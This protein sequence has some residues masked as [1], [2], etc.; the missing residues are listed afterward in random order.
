MKDEIYR[1][2]VNERSDLMFKSYLSPQFP[3]QVWNLKPLSSKSAQ[4]SV[5]IKWQAKNID[6]SNENKTAKKETANY[7]KARD[8]NSD[9]RIQT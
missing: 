4:K 8:L 3:Q 6:Y 9:G 2:N 5:P 7:F 1:E